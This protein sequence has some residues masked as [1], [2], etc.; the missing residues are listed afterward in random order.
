MKV[1][2]VSWVCVDKGTH[3]PAVAALTNSDVVCRLSGL[4]EVDD[5]H[6]TRSR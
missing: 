2:G 3:R 6:D 1:V 4:L 5:S